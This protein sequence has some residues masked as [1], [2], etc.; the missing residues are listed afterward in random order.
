MREQIVEWHPIAGLNSPCAGVQIA[1][2][3]GE[4]TLT[5]L[6]SGVIGGS[7]GDLQLSFGRVLAFMSHE[8]STHPWNDS[9]TPQPTLKTGTAL[10]GSVT[11][12]C[13]EVVESE[14]IQ[15]FGDSRLFGRGQP[16]HFQV[17]TL[18]KSVDVLTTQPVRGEWLGA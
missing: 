16:R 7:A 13:L 1:E 5:L 6:F 14:W 3:N 15:S 10:G 18:D 17:V 9:Q 12:P 2:H 4:L 8:E 11:F